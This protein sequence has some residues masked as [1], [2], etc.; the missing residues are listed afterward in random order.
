MKKKIKKGTAE[1]KKFIQDQKEKLSI[2]RFKGLGEM[3]PIQLKQTTMDPKKRKLILI[4][5]KSADFFSNNELVQKL[6]GK[7]PEPRFDY[8][9]ENAEFIE[10]KYI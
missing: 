1:F 7:N 6:M 5:S 10:T 8:I 9:I 2:Q 4:N 3:N